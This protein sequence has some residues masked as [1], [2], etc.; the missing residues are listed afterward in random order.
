M[1]INTNIKFNSNEQE[2]MS[3][4]REV[5]AK[6]APSTQA[7][8][9]GG[10]VRDKLIGVE[11]Q[12]MDIMVYP[13]RAEDFA[14]L[15][16]KHLDIKDPHIIK[17]NP[18][19]SKFISTSKVFLPTQNGIMEIDIAQARQDVYRDNS[20][21]PET[22]PATPQEDMFRRDLTINAIAYSINENKIVDFT[23]KGIS[24]LQNDIIRTPQDPLKTFMD[25]PLRIFRVIRFSAKYNFKID[26]QTYAAIL[27]PRLRDE[28]KNKVSKERIGAEITKT[29]SNPNAEYAITLL[30]NTGLLEDIITESIKGTEYE[31]K[32]D[33]LE[34]NQENPNHKLNLWSHTMEVVK[35]VL[36]KYKEAEP[37]K[38]MVMILAA[39]FHDIG[40]LYREIWAESKT[41]PGHRSYHGH[42][43]VSAKIIELIFKY[44]K[45]E[46]YIK[47]VSG[48]AASHMRPH[49]LVR[50]EGGIKAMRRFIRNISEQSLNWLDVFNIAVADAYAKDV[51]RDPETVKEYQELEQ[52][53][54]EALSSIGQLQD[55]SKNKIAPIL[56]GNEIMDTFNNQNPGAW[57]KTVTNW[58][59][60]IQDQEPNI[61]K[62]E[63]RKKIIE[64][65][66]EYIKKTITASK[67]SKILID[68]TI[69]KINTSIKD[70][71]TEA[72]SVAKKLMEEY[73]E[74]ED[75]VLLCLKT[76]IKAKKI[77]HNSLIG[78]DLVD[79][80]RKIA[81][82]NFLVPEIILNY[83]IAL[84]LSGQVMK[85]ED[86]KFLLR[87]IKMNPEKTIKMIKDIWNILGN[88]NKNA[89]IGILK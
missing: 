61:S 34:M 39:L 28:I 36:E 26:P 30:K 60:D 62:E 20:R 19:K 67:C 56:N 44:L 14:R 70:R 50:D 65:F 27:N 29:L 68:S 2:V 73:E 81:K 13:I 16:T 55:P 41:H 52:H 64:N 6:Y 49:L 51:I 8:L 48:I 25:D 9:V 42:E 80:G 24:D 46:N 79:I 89:L 58:L 53:L 83:V 31:G 15:I 32:I 69:D 1:K 18:E 88:N 85:D 40:K 12:D 63:A 82:E 7:Y 78:S 72:V 4:I 77:N 22:K 10:S 59:L 45:I 43:E 33:E 75:V 54:Q 37:E 84:M 86:K 35:G 57:I 87:A 38:R 71:P 47:E 66:P 5:I 76:A 11:S 74:D 21:I 23:G 17:D 3:I